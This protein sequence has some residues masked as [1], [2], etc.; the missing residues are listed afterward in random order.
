MQ[1]ALR[2][3][4]LVS[5][6]RTGPVKV[7]LPCASVS[8]RILL[9]AA[10]IAASQPRTAAQ[11]SATAAQPADVRPVVRDVRLS[12]DRQ[13]TLKVIDGGGNP[14]AG[15]QLTVAHRG[16]P[17]ARAVSSSQGTVTVTNLRPGLHTI[18]S[19]GRSVIYR[20]WTAD[21]APPSAV[22]NPAFVL[23]DTQVRGQYGGGVMP[24][25]V[26]AAGVT[27]TALAIVLIGKNDSDNHQP[28]PASL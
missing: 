6:F 1:C 12:A 26:L 24:T 5:E 18:Q 8:G 7:H 2:H 16:V 28:V 21:S 27:A 22:Q 10:L 13:L 23:S 9:A 15:R 19:G 14:S 11:D 4:V 25:A 3:A 20:F 17:V